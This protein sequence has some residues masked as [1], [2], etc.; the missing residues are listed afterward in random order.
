M[1]IDKAKKLIAKQLKKGHKG[2]PE[3]SIEYFGTSGNCATKVAVRFI[4]EEGAE[5]QEEVFSSQ[6]DIRESEVVQSAL[7][8]I[9]Q[10]AD[11]KSVVQVDGVSAL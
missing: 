8:K 4:L 9:I 6:T 7:V 5:A 3:I 10:R 2:Y 11:A 1:H